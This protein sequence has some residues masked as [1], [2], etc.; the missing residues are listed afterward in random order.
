MYLVRCYRKICQLYI[1]CQLRDRF[2]KLVSREVHNAIASTFIFL[3]TLIMLETSTLHI[4]YISR[5][6]LS[7]Q[8]IS[9]IM[10]FLQWQIFLLKK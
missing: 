5:P 9:R 2:L 1:T 8:P 3:V 7:I 10:F 6:N 4:F